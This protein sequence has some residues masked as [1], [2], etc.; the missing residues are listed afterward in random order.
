MLLCTFPKP[1]NLTG[2]FLK[3]LNVKLKQSQLRLKHQQTTNKLSNLT[4]SSVKSSNI[5]EKS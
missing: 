2:F 4:L 1:R 5:I 3:E